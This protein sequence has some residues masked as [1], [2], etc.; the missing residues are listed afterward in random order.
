MVIRT[1][2][3]VLGCGTQSMGLGSLVSRLCWWQCLGECFP[4]FKNWQYLE[5]LPLLISFG[6]CWA[7]L[8]Y[9][10]WL[11]VLFYIWRVKLVNLTWASMLISIHMD[12][13][14]LISGLANSWILALEASISNLQHTELAC[15]GG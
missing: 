2:K 10:P 5:C 12:H 14:V 15:C 11:L 3:G 8:T 13:L 6:R 9:G 4:F 7:L 1:Q